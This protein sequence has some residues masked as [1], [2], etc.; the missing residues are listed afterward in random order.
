MLL[1]HPQKSIVRAPF[2]VG[3][4]SWRKPTPVWFPDHKT[5]RQLGR[6]LTEFEGR[7]SA[8]QLPA[9]IATALRG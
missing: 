1:D 8:L 9:I 3:V 7:P 4:A 2:R 5:L 6:L